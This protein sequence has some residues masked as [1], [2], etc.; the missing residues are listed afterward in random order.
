M[1]GA[2]SFGRTK[3]VLQVLALAED[4][5]LAER[6]VAELN[7]DAEVAT[8]RLVETE[9]G[10]NAVQ[11]IVRNS[12]AVA[13]LWTPRSCIHN[14]M[15][16]IAGAAFGR[17]C[18]IN[19]LHGAVE[20]PV[21]FSM[22]QHIELDL[23]NPI[24]HGLS[25]RV[26][27][28]QVFLRNPLS[29]VGDGQ[30]YVFVSYSRRDVQQLEPVLQFLADLA[31]PYWIDRNI[32]A[33]VWSDEINRHLEKSAAVLVLWTKNSCSSAWVSAEASY[34][35]Q[36]DKLIGLT[37]EPCDAPN[38]LRLAKSAAMTEV[39]KIVPALAKL[40]KTE[41]MSVIMDTQKFSSDWNGRQ[42]Y[43]A[44]RKDEA[45][46]LIASLRARL[47]AVRSEGTYW[48]NVLEEFER[49][50]KATEDAPIQVRKA[51]RY[52]PPAPHPASVELKEP[53]WLTEKWGTIGVSVIAIF[54]MLVFIGVALL[55]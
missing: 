37:L 23:N 9:V 22:V 45:L 14:D 48:A 12:E 4:R 8:M 46:A 17:S 24:G 44:E 19:L 15:R 43:E 6:I 10:S 28:A 18:L 54:V 34:A 41:Q 11:N 30:P 52:K 42:I 26:L 49:V 50:A 53:Y 36:S 3:F 47:P 35:F 5:E 51:P 55:N 39:E 32:V 27:A 16:E 13:A 33:G 31:I 20:L 38:H 21:V 29:T 1:P 2:M 7:R 25:E 40:M